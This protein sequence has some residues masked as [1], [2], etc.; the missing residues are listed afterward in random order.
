MMDNEGSNQVTEK[1][2][3]FKP[4][5]FARGVVDAIFRRKCPPYYTIEQKREWGRGF[6]LERILSGRI[7]Q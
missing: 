2:Q 4:S 6:N 3:G 7:N 1:P 5:P